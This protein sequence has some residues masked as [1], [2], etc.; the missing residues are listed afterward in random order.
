MILTCL[1]C[2]LMM[3]ISSVFCVGP[4]FQSILARSY[5]EMH[6][7]PH[8]HQADAFLIG[9]WIPDSRYI[10]G[11]YPDPMD[12]PV[13]IQMIHS[14]TS[15][16][17]KGILFHCFIHQLEKRYFQEME[18]LYPNMLNQEMGWKATFGVYQDALLKNIDIISKGRLLLNDKLYTQFNVSRLTETYEASDLM[19]WFYT[20]FMFLCTA[21]SDKA[22]HFEANDSYKGVSLSTSFSDEMLETMRTEIPKLFNDPYAVN[23]ILD[24][25]KSCIE[26]FR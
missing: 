18:P 20:L 5:I 19:L 4:I 16:V 14:E 26:S 24:F 25:K 10:N 2:L 17:K 11:K 8:E 23:S 3:P 13:D 12:I 6:P 22:D 15:P 1:I 21:I 9:V 7:F